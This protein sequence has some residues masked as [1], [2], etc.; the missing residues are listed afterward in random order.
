MQRVSCINVVNVEVVSK[1]DL[2][3]SDVGK[4]MILCAG[5]VES[6]LAVGFP[7]VAIRIAGESD[8]YSPQYSKE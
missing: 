5:S 4:Q 8:G 7:V 6:E 1:A 3:L 2:S